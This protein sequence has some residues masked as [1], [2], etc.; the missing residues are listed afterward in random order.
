MEAIENTNKFA[1]MVEE[2]TLDKA[3]KYPTLYG[4]N[5]REQWKELIYSKF[6]EKIKND[7]LELPSKIINKYENYLKSGLPEEYSPY[8]IE[9]YE[10]ALK[11]SDKDGIKEYQK[12]LL[13]NLR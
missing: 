1:D 4:D 10:K 13:K 3:F 5:V 7:V 8:P 6:N 12:R 2:F 9:I 11:M